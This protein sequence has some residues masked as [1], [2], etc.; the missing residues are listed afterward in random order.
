MNV[1]SN[2]EKRRKK[3]CKRVWRL[4]DNSDCPCGILR[5][6]YI[7]EKILEKIKDKYISSARLGYLCYQVDSKNYLET[8]FP[9]SSARWL[10]APD[11]VISIDLYKVI[12]LLCLENKIRCRKGVV[13]RR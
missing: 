3:R 6:K 4:S 13:T 7:V 9:V 5:L 1:G 11:G 2:K 10:K 12:F 8:G